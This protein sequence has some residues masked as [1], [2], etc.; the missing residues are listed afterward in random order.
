MLRNIFFLCIFEV[1]F[2]GC[3]CWENIFFVGSYKN[4]LYG[5][6]NSEARNYGSR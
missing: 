1:L 4:S 6:G 5:I 3:N 2:K